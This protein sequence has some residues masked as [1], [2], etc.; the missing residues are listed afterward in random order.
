MSALRNANIA[1][2]AT[3]AILCPLCATADVAGYLSPVDRVGG[4]G[5]W[6]LSWSLAAFVFK[7]GLIGVFAW[8]SLKGVVDGVRNIHCKVRGIPPATLDD[9]PTIMDSIFGIF[10][11]LIV[12]VMVGALAWF[13][14]FT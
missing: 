7:W 13:Y 3:L 10:F 4:G 5:L 11:S 14:I 9:D 2:V 1:C 12:L 6:D 8:G